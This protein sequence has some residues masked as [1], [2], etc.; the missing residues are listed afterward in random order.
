MKQARQLKEVTA[1]EQPL[2]V[3]RR[4][5]LPA[6]RIPDILL[7]HTLLPHVLDG[8]LTKEV[9]YLR[10]VL[11]L[12]NAEAHVE[13]LGDVVKV[14]VPQRLRVLFRRGLENTILAAAEATG[15]HQLRT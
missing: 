15:K 7:P 12:G 14:F 13:M 8:F 2:Q 3:S 4:P 5:R 6:Q 11:P 1:F 10:V 9:L